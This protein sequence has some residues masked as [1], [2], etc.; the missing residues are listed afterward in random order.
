ME[1]KSVKPGSYAFNIET[2]FP[3]DT[4][5]TAWKT[6]PV[7]V[8]VGGILTDEQLKAL[9]EWLTP[10]TK[11][12]TEFT[13]ERPDESSPVYPLWNNVDA[14]K[15]HAWAQ[16]RFVVMLD[17]GGKLA[18]HDFG[19][20]VRYVDSAMVMGTGVAGK[21]A[22]IPESIKIA[23]QGRPM[24]E[25][26]AHPIFHGIHWESDIPETGSVTSITSQKTLTG[27]GCLIPLGSKPGRNFRSLAL[28]RRQTL[29]SVLPQ[30]LPKT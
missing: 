28:K 4:H 6:C 5:I 25:M 21:P 23:A 8:S 13:C 27:P 1:I 2:R 11:S 29:L 9:S 12:M 10:E 19:F 3:R 17:L 30:Y 7:T 14:V 26:L 20:N 24:T 15:F 22:T 16:G 18:D